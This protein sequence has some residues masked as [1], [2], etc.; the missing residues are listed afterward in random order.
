MAFGECL[1]IR[2]RVVRGSPGGSRRR[3]GRYAAVTVEQTRHEERVCT[4]DVW[5]PSWGKVNGK[6]TRE[7]EENRGKDEEKM[8]AQVSLSIRGGR[9]SSAFVQVASREYFYEKYEVSPAML[10]Y[11][12]ETPLYGPSDIFALKPGHV[13]V[14][15]E[16][17][18]ETERASERVPGVRG[19]FVVKNVLSDIERQRLMELVRHKLPRGG[20]EETQQEG[21]CLG[22]KLRRNSVA[23]VLADEPLLGTLLERMRGALPTHSDEAMGGGSLA[24][25]NARWRV[26]RYRANS[27]EI[28][29]P[30][31]DS[32]WPGS[33]LDDAGRLTYDAFGDRISRMTMLLYLNDDYDGGFTSFFPG[34]SSAREVD[35]DSER[36]GVKVPAGSALCFWHGDHE[37]S[38]V[39]EGS[40]VLSE[41]GAKYV[42][43]TDILYHLSPTAVTA[44]AM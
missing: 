39:H 2:R 12:S 5:A 9:Q 6:S 40:P 35:T 28:F 18:E 17:E 34:C 33:G 26:Y 21:V 29:K 22:A 1:R 31:I 30:H 15:D 32:P 14:D 3:G 20:W 36:L 13:V 8:S 16:E 24:G 42:V 4:G 44:D 7:D 27:G 23:V 25:I 11:L 38:P 43:R 10:S 41:D 19:A 37:D